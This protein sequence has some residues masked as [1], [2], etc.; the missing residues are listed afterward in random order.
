M[1]S[2][3]PGLAHQV[4]I[5]QFRLSGK[6]CWAASSLGDGDSR[7]KLKGWGRDGRKETQTEMEE[8]DSFGARSTLNAVSLTR[9][10]GQ[11]IHT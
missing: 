8:E 11:E 10:H 4:T 2:K 1:P 3:Y 7:A 5:Q 6:L 9:A